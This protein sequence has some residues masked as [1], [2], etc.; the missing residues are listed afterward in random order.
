MEKRERAVM[1]LPVII[2]N[3]EY[4]L[5]YSKMMY[6][7]LYT[8]M[9]VLYNNGEVV[10]DADETHRCLYAS[11]GGKKCEELNMLLQGLSEKRIKYMNAT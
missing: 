2:Q 10:F 4:R 11:H 6:E 5:L 9:I 1:S 3:Q 8:K 7:P